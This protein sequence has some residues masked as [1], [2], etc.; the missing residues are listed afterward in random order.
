VSRFNNDGMG[1]LYRLIYALFCPHFIELTEAQFQEIEFEFPRV[2][3]DRE[4][5]ADSFKDSPLHCCGGDIATSVDVV[6]L[7]GGRGVKVSRRGRCP[8]CSG[9]QKHEMRMRDGYLMAKNEAGEWMLAFRQDAI[10]VRWFK[11]MFKRGSEQ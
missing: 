3:Y 5:I 6:E 9:E 1:R 2:D 7:Y 10:V 4:Q 11:S 8:R